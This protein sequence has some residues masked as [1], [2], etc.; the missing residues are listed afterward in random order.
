MPNR[1]ENKFLISTVVAALLNIGLNILLM[2]RYGMNAAAFTTLV[3]EIVVV[4][5]T[6]YYSLKIIRF[7]IKLYF[8]LSLVV[9]VLF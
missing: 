2:P 3:A 8:K 5:V 1:Q 7:E 6:V 9:F 4:I